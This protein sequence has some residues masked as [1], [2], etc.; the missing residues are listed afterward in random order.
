LDKEYGFTST[1]C[2]KGMVRID[3]NTGSPVSKY[4]YIGE[5]PVKFFRVIIGENYILHVEV[6]TV[7]RTAMNND[8]QD[9]FQSRMALRFFTQYVV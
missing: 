3:V 4:M 5:Y 7:V 2:G 6:S 8:P 1:L 9:D